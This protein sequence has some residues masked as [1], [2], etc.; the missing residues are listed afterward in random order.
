MGGSSDNGAKKAAKAQQAMLHQQIAE[1][2]A[3]YKDA[4]GLYQPYSDAGLGGLTS[5]LDLLGQNGNDAQ[6]Q[7]ISGLE[8]TPGYQAQ[9]ESG[10]RAVLQNASA[11][12]GLRGGN[13]QQG[14]AEFGSGLFGNYYQ[15]ML[16]QLGALQQQGM[17]VQTNLANARMG[18]AGNVGNAYS[19][20]GDAQA[21]GILGG[22]GGGQ[23]GG[24]GGMAS[25]ALSG[26]A[27]GAMMGSVVPGIGTMAG[28]IGGGVL[29][30][31][32]GK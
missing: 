14:L 24:F 20:M 32:G 12:G 27:S 30:A 6:A 29:G 22:Q 28:A 13:V 5:Y 9:L 21:Q 25:G 8:Q 18:V 26:A 4:K 1:Q 10:Q 17:N 3:A 7:A 11:T 16:G 15:N 31:L 19:A 23:G 2:K